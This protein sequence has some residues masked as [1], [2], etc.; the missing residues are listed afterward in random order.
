MLWFLLLTSAVLATLVLAMFL[1]PVKLDFIMKSSPRWRLKIGA[2]LFGGLSPPIIIHDSDHRGSK[3]DKRLKSPRE[4][5][6]KVKM[7][8]QALVRIP[9]AIAAAPHLLADLLRPIHIEQLKVDADI[10]LGDPADT[11]RVF[12]LFAPMIY[13]WPPADTVS[14]AV[15]PNFSASRI[16]GEIIAKLSFIPVAFVLPAARFAWHIYGPYS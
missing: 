9:G 14:I 5:K 13:S 6:Q 15:R 2:R 11:G 3:K 1:T 12:G 16:S 8:R 10:G 4:R 7:S